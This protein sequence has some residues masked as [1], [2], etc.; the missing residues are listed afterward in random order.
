M[1]PTIYRRFCDD[2]KA[3]DDIELSRLVDLSYDEPGFFREA[4]AEFADAV[5]DT[6]FDRLS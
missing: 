5:D 6:I 3:L 4:G 2:L 1:A